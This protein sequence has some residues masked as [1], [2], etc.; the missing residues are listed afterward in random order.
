MILGSHP[1]AFDS[2]AR[3]ISRKLKNLT[4]QPVTETILFDFE[5]I[6]DLQIEPE[7]LAHAKETRQAKG[8]ISRDRPLPMNDLVDAT[9]RHPDVLGEPILAKAH[10]PQE[11]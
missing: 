9:G 6:A 8:G 11:L 1:G 7:A 4:I 5:I 10:W 2:L 3:W